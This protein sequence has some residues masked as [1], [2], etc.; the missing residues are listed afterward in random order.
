MLF[1]KLSGMSLASKYT[2]IIPPVG[3]SCICEVMSH[4]ILYMIPLRSIASIPTRLPFS[5]DGMFPVS[6]PTGP[7]PGRPQVISEVPDEH[8]HHEPTPQELEAHRELREAVLE[9][10]RKTMSNIIAR[11]L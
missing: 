4:V 5:S 1:S 6:E 7:M 3:F 2:V 11:Y 10:S 8:V 9:H